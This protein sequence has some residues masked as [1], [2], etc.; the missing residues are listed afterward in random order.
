MAVLAWTPGFL[1]S[2]TAATQYSVQ[3]HTGVSEGH[4]AWGHP[5]TH[6]RESKTIGSWS[7][8]YTL[9]LKVAWPLR[10]PIRQAQQ[11]QSHRA[12]RGPRVRAVNSSHT[13]EP[14]VRVEPGR[15]QIQSGNSVQRSNHGQQHQLIKNGLH[16]LF[17]RKQVMKEHKT[18]SLIFREKRCL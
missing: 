8:L 18:I 7:L 11:S 9:S 6:H 13:E 17:Q 16:V 14:R 2:F 3:N 4:S 1:A 15:D 12:R 5:A 10:T